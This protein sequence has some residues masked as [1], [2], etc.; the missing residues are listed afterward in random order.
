M[1]AD[2]R[3]APAQGRLSHRTVFDGATGDQ[4]AGVGV[5]GPA[6]GQRPQRRP[7]HG[8]VGVFDGATG[9]EVAGV[10]VSGPAGG[11]RP[12]RRFPH[13][14]VGVVGGASG[15]RCDRHS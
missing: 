12:H 1:L 6:R 8:R 9:E 4:V 5:S 15:E 2:T 11:Q 3:A 14:L 7:S 13:L 10:G